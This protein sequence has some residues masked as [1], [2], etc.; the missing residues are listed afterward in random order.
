MKRIIW[1]SMPDFRDWKEDLR[2]EY[3]DNSEEELMNIMYEINWD[4]LNDERANLN[5]N[6]DNEIVVIAELGLWN[7]RR[8]GY[9]IIESGVIS[10]CLKPNCNDSEIEWFVD[11][12][13]EFRASETHHD[14][15]NYYRYRY[16]KDISERAKEDFLSKIF[17]G[18]VTS[19]DIS[20]Y[21][22]SVG[23]EIRKVYGW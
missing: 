11:G 17:E 1:T 16:F 21:T 12:R 22:R 5:I 14:G 6:L 20:R 19:A 13:G 18:T 7:G 2:T 3:P 10:D 8:T 4:Y 15:T 9:K 23:K